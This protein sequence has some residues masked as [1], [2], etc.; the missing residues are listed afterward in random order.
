[1]ANPWTKEEIDFLC[2][3]YAQ[4]GVKYCVKH[5]KRFTALQVSSKAS[6]VGVSLPR[7]QLRDP[8]ECR[9]NLN[10]IRPSSPWAI[11]L[12]FG[13]KS[14]KDIPNYTHE[15]PLYDKLC[16]VA[17]RIHT[18]IEHDL[19]LQHVSKS[20]QSGNLRGRRIA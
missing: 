20:A 18:E 9:A 5:L 14:E 19:A 3:H 4:D 6:Y 15:A 7:G 1:M 12:Q 17:D 2:R 8:V 16:G 10:R 11:H 13:R